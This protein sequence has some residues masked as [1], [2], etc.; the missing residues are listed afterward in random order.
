[1]KKSSKPNSTAT[2]RKSRYL[3]REQAESILNFLNREELP[4]HDSPFK[5]YF[6]DKLI[7]SANPPTAIT[8]DPIINP[9]TN[10]DENQNY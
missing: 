4:E 7:G 10:Q 5:I 8:N 1:M 6:N 9:K 3:T 2:K